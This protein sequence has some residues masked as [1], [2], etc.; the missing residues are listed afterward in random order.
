MMRG[1]SGVFLARLSE[2]TGRRRGFL[3]TV[4]EMMGRLSGGS[5]EL[6]LACAAFPH[7]LFVACRYRFTYHA[8]T[9]QEIG[10][11]LLVFMCR[12]QTSTRQAVFVSRA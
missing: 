9:E 11:R 6:T 12:N 8:R 2:M 7:P 3:G 10:L 4:S 5:D 1:D